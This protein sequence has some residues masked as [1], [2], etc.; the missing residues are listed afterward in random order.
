MNELKYI[1]LFEAFDSDRLSKT[2]NFIDK[3][4]K[5]KFLTDLKNVC[6]SIDFPYSEISDEYIDYLPFKRALSATK[7]STDRLS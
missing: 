1:K 7:T 6:N 5:K 3:D 4:S 2:L